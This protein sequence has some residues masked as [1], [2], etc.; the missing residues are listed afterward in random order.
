MPPSQI[1]A[2]GGFDDIVSQD[3]RFL[4]EAAKIGEVTVLLWPDAVLEEVT[5]KAPKCSLAERSYFLNA[6]RYIN[7]VVKADVSTIDL[8]SFT[9][10]RLA[11]L[12]S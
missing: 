4:E 12:D 5:G 3:I 11:R 2:S 6:V 8:C 7:K 9:W 1:V 10:P